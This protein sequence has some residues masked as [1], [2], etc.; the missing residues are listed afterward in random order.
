MVRLAALVVALTFAVPSTGLARRSD[1]HAYRMDQMWSTVVRLLR[2]DYG[3]SIRDRDREIGYLLF[4]YPHGN[5]TVPGSIELVEVEEGGRPQVRVTLSIPAMPGYVERMIL[6]R[7][8][9]KLR[10]D[11]GQPMLAPRREPREQEVQEEDHTHDAEEGASE[12]SD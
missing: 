9:R 8:T 5:R 11:H 2:V 10:E 3:F 1:T 6:D 12:T 7:F 4:D